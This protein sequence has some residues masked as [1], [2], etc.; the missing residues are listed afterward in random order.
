MAEKMPEN[1]S[2]EGIAL[3]LAGCR[4]NVSDHHV[5]TYHA[6]GATGR[7]LYCR[8]CGAEVHLL[9]PR[10][11]TEPVELAPTPVPTWTKERLEQWA[12]ADLGE[13]AVVFAFGQQ[14]AADVAT[15]G[16][17][18]YRV[19]RYF[20]QLDGDALKWKHNHPSAFDSLYGAQSRQYLRDLQLQQFMSEKAGGDSDGR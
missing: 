12:K 4:C 1:M 5:A 14:I 15:P 20:L 10:S 19:T 8:E 3:R 18:G 11:T 2:P 6:G 9:E 17:L 16:P 7:T 13:S